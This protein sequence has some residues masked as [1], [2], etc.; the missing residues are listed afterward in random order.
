MTSLSYVRRLVQLA[1]ADPVE[2]ADRA[3][4]QLEMRLDRPPFEQPEVRGGVWLDDVHR[5]LGLDAPCPAC[6]DVLPPLWDTVRTELEQS[7]HRAGKGY[8]AGRRLAEA[9]YAT[10]FHLAPPSVIETGVARG[11]TS[12]FLLEALDRTSGGTL[13]SIDLPPNSEGWH[14][15]SGVAVPKRLHTNWRF[16]RGSSRRLLPTCT[17]KEAPLQ[18]FVHDSLH[19]TA[20]VLFELRTV[21]PTLA[22]G[23]VML[24]DDVEDNSG[25]ARFVDEVDSDWVVAKEAERS[26]L[27]G[28]IRKR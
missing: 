25:F 14:E 18:L 20:H 15:E 28:A 24:V 6:D 3:R 16:L 10:A 22:S 23:G 26:G 5:L 1:L 7:G 17:T 21:W 27:I 19:T 13:W 2:F 11:V 4:G 12:R 9:A 8:D